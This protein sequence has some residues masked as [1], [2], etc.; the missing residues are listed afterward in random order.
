MDERKEYNI[1]LAD[2][3]TMYGFPDG[4]GNFIINEVIEKDVLNSVN[5]SE[6]KIKIEDMVIDTV[7]NQVLRTHYF[8]N[9]GKTFIRFSDM[10]ELEKIEFDYNSKLDYI[11]CMTGV[12]LDE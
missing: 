10:N 6:V 5:L 12:D 11:A 1:V 8:L 3:T 4:A 7:T 9:D 2:G